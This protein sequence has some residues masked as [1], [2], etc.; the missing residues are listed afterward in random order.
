MGSFHGGAVALSVDY[1]SL[2]KCIGDLTLGG[3]ERGPLTFSR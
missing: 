3:E 2:G 1:R